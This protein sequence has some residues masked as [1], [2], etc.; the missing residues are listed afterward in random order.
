[1]KTFLIGLVATIACALT[2]HLDAATPTSKLVPPTQ[3]EV[4][5][6]VQSWGARNRHH[7]SQMIARNGGTPVKEVDDLREAVGMGYARG[8]AAASRKT[9]L[10]ANPYDKVK[11]PDPYLAWAAG[12]Y[13]VQENK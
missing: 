10:T 5:M 8:K 6:W 13:S 9:A 2:W 7:Y 1:M 4:T 11:D 12:W 3:Q